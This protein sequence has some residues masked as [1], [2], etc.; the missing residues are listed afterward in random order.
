MSREEGFCTFQIIWRIDAYS[1]S[2][3]N[4]N[5]NCVAVLEPSQLLETFR[6][7]E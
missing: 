5:F 2:V 7:F 6:N 3:G 1:L 4:A